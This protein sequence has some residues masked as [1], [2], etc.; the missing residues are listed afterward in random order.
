MDDLTSRDLEAKLESAMGALRTAERRA[1]AGQ[2]AL[3]LLHE[4]KNP[5]EALGYLTYLTCESA[6]DADEVRRYVS[7]AEEQLGILTQIVTQTLGF[8][9]HSSASK[10]VELVTLAEAALRIHQRRIDQKKVKL[11]KSLPHGVFAHVLT[12]EMLQ[13]ISN[14]VSN[15]LDAL[16][17]D[18]ALH[19]RIRK[20]RGEVHFVVADNGHGIQPE[21]LESLFEPFFTT[22][23]DHG[24]GLGLAVSKNIVERHRGKIRIRSSV[25]PGRSGTTFRI[26]IPA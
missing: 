15:A 3:E 14:L 10:P 23:G 6:H 8:A 26:S 12:G 4:I 22:K 5:L 19:L 20:C 25:T 9:Q 1:V 16:P 11:V 7:L 17:S 18:G 24:T 2:L 13:V 21:H